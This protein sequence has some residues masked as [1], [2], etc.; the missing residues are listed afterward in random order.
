MTLREGNN[1][2]SLDHMRHILR[3]ALDADYTFMTCHEFM[4]T[5]VADLPEKVF[6]MKHDLDVKP[7]TLPPLLDL[8]LSL[9]IKP[10]VYVRVC[11]ND[12]NVMDYRV[13]PMLQ[14]YENR[15]V[16][17]GL[18]TNFWEY[19]KITDNIPEVVLEAE[20]SLLKQ[21]L[22]IR[23]MSTHRDLNYAHNA[24]PWVEENW[25]WLKGR[26]DLDY[27]AYDP[28]LMDNMV[29][30]NEGYSPHLCWRN[31]TPEEAIATGQHVYML[32]HNHWWWSDHPFET[33]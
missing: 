12:Y 30:V 10:T 21:F 32:T 9:G 16:E 25:K 5:L 15:G 2:W 24:L 33:W 26:L 8:E 29:Y 22:T 20:V 1:D 7:Q 14:A 4:R 28:K 27:Q 18:H 17:I 11:A 19:A 23:G 3:L 6:I 13:M 31:K